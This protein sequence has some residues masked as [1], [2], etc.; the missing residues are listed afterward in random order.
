MFGDTS[1]FAVGQYGVEEM[2][3][4]LLED[5][6]NAFNKLSIGEAMVFHCPTQHLADAIAEEYA[7]KKNQFVRSQKNPDGK[8]LVAIHKTYGRKIGGCL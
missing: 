5:C 4:R 6:A 1:A 2:R 7:R 3:N 8:Y